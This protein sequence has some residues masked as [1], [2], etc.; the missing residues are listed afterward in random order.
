MSRGDECTHVLVVCV[1]FCFHV[2]LCF[3]ECIDVAF[4]FRGLFVRGCSSWEGREYL[5]K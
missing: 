5:E 4:I 1:S 3:C 2:C